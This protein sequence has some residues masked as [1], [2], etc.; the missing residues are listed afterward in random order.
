MAAEEIIMVRK[1]CVEIL[2]FY[3]EFGMS[4]GHVEGCGRFN[5]DLTI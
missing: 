4:Y 2:F 5:I 1:Y 3:V